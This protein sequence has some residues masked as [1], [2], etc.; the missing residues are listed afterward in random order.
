MKVLYVGGTGQISFDCVHESVR[1]GHET[2][3]F[4]RGNSNAG[5]PPEVRY[6]TGDFGDDDAYGR[7][8]EMGFDVVCQFRV[9]GVDQLRRDL[10]LLAGR[11]G[12]YVFISSASAYHKPV[13]VM[14]ITEDVPL[15]NPYWGYSRAKAE[16]E[17]LL[18]GQTAL[19]WTIVRPSHTSRDMLISAI[20][21]GDLLASRMRRGK[22]I[23]VH[24]DGTSLWTVTA[25]ADFAPPFVRL[26]GNDA[27]VGEDF[28]L[29]A[30]HATSW[31][32]LMEATGAA[33]G[34]EPDLCHVPTDTLVRYEPGWEGP[35]WGDKSWSVLFDNTK[36]KSVVGDFSCDTPLETFM[37]D[38]V[39]AFEARGGASA[40]ADAELDALFDR[41]AADQRALGVGG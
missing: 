1:A 9:F 16:C 5:L 32:R 37:A 19:P 22:P 27:A 41:I 21:G 17:A 30:D 26:L 13:R 38:R 23:V 36:I 20:G 14:R 3:V 28:H 18:R 6:V 10:E 11:V 24:G 4:N 8:A 29:T 35:L 25:S 7:V 33:L 12:Q 34:V 40:G 31:N 39:A 15:V 2:W